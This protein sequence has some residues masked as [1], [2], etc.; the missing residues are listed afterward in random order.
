MVFSGSP[1]CDQP[2]YTTLILAPHHYRRPSRALLTAG[3]CGRG[4]TASWPVIGGSKDRVLRWHIPHCSKIST[5]SLTDLQCTLCHLNTSNFLRTYPHTTEYC[6]RQQFVLPSLYITPFWRCGDV[7]TSAAD[8][9]VSRLEK[10]CY[11]WYDGLSS[12]PGPGEKQ[13]C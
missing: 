6:T 12:H 7:V 9:R 10:L 3:S 13:Y 8:R 1:P 5:P 4:L 2:V 11:L